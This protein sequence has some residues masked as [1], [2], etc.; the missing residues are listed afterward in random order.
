MGQFAAILY[1]TITQRGQGDDINCPHARMLAVMFGHI[2]QF[3]GSANRLKHGLIN[4]FGR[5]DHISA[6]PVMIRIS[7]PAQNLHM[8]SVAEAIEN[9]LNFFL[10][11]ALTKIRRC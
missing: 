9:L 2:D 8:F 1:R 6:K 4:R 3:K 7:L 10:I 5:T 11:A